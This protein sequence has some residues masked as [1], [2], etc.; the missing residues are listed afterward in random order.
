MN[1]R[2]RVEQILS[3]NSSDRIP[4]DWWATD[5]TNKKVMEDL[6]ANNF[7]D[8][9]EK[10]KIDF[11][12]IKGPEYIGPELVKRNDGTFEDIWGTFFKKENIGCEYYCNVMKY[13]L[14]DAVALDDVKNYNH[15]PSPDWFDYSVIYDQCTKHR[16]KVIIFMGD[17][18]NRISQLKAAIYLRGMENILIDMYYNKGIFNFIINKIKEFYLEY[19]KRILEASKGKLDIILPGDDFGTQDNLIMSKDDW[20]K[21]FKLG[22]K[23]YIK[24]AHSFNV[25][26]MHHSCGSVYDLIAEFIDCELD[27]LQSIQPEAYMMDLYRIKRNFGKN[28]CFQGGISIQKSLPFGSPE[29]VKSEVGQA[30]NAMK[31]NGGYIAC[32]SHNIQ[33]DTPL[34]NIFALIEAYNEHGKY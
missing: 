10:F 22:F 32:T 7:N 34:E 1:S 23:E 25:K 30:L 3:H 12:Y 5:R 31:E 19:E 15:W 28:I 17:R 13:P 4:R 9:L 8:V 6:K 2:I 14:K 21:N 24:M 27:I 20:K 16:N 33:S 29:E 11:R 18:L 26:V